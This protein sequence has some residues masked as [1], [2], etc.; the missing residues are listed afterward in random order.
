MRSRWLTLAALLALAPGLVAVAR[1]EAPVARPYLGVMVEAAKD[2]DHPGAV[3]RE[4]TPISPAEQAGLKNGDLIVKVD[5]KDV[6]GPDA[7]VKLVGEHKP[8]DKLALHVM[9]DGKDQTVNV[10]LAERPAEK[11]KAA[12]TEVFLGV[13]SRPLTPELKDHLGITVDKGAVVMTVMPDSPAAKAGLQRDDVVTGVNDQ[14][15]STPEELRAAVQ[16]A[17]VGK[18]VTLKLMRGKDTKEIK[19]QLAETP[20]GFGRLSGLKLPE[21]LSP[22]MQRHFEELQNRFRELH[23]QDEE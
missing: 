7:L 18:E 16:K 12:K 8:G 17:G 3:V 9:R 13:W 5:D 11:K 6:K 1:A 10:T 22:E 4:V 2:V 15:V 20:F 14:A 19:A 23:E 21:G